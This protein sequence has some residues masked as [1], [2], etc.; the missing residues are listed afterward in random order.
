MTPGAGAGIL[1]LGH[2]HISHI[3]KMLFF[4]KNVVVMITKDAGIFRQVIEF[5]Y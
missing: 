5:C 2:G 4:F 1:A 3:V